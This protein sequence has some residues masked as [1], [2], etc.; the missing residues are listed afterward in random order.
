M[1]GGGGS[2]LRQAQIDMTQFNIHF[3]IFFF[4]LCKSLRCAEER[5]QQKHAWINN[6]CDPVTLHELKV[7]V[8]E[9]WWTGLMGLRAGLEAQHCHLSACL[10]AA[11]SQW[12]TSSYWQ[13]WCFPQTKRQLLRCTARMQECA[14]VFTWDVHVINVLILENVSWYLNMVS[15]RSISAQDNTWKLFDK[16]RK[17]EQSFE[18]RL[19]L[20]GQLLQWFVNISSIW[21]IFFNSLY[22]ITP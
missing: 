1:S 10:G 18:R 3:V 19:R 7:C 4:P 2:G 6:S 14:W 15:E 11:G 16:Q 13:S 9:F 17:L 21:C 12:I 8:P 22:S 5:N 20:K